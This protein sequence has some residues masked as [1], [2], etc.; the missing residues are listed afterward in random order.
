MITSKQQLRD[1]LSAMRGE[2]KTMTAEQFKAAIAKV[3]LSQQRA[4]IFFGRSPRSGQRWALGE[5]DIPYDVAGC[6][7]YM[8]EHGI[9]AESFE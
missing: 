9:Q 1:T 3:G 5:L 6:L 8:V 2:G 7:A 4:G